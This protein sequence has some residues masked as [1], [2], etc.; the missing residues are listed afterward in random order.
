MICVF[1]QSNQDDHGQ[2]RSCKPVEVPST[3]K[4]CHQV[5]HQACHQVSFVATLLVFRCHQFLHTSN[6]NPPPFM[7]THHPSDL[8]LPFIT[9]FS[10]QLSNSSQQEPYQSCHKVPSPVHVKVAR[11]VKF[12][13]AN[14]FFIYCVDVTLPLLF[15]GLSLKLQSADASDDLLN[16]VLSYILLSAL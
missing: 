8:S 12:I 13:F 9:Q 6:P 16:T 10:T 7:C 11:Q 5:P 2:V 1:F 3:Q 14:V 15:L 4:V